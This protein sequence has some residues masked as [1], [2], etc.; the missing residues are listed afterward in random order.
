MSHWTY[1]PFLLVWALPVIVLQWLA[2]GRRLWRERRWWPWIALGLGA[3][4]S[5]ADAVAIAAGIWRFDTPS[6][7]GVAVVNVPLEEILFYILTSFMLVQ[8]FVIFW[9]WEKKRAAK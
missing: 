5:L 8:G 2:G 6:L 1:L 7:V 9:P 3:Y 4:L